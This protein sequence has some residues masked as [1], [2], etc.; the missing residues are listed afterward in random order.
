[1]ALKKKQ[2][3]VLQ[4][5]TLL[6]TKENWNDSSMNLKLNFYLTDYLF[7]FQNFQHI[8][9]QDADR[10]PRDRGNHETETKIR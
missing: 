8:R 6:E 3:D 4:E 2:Y 1:M 9:D 7:L 10:G 5:K